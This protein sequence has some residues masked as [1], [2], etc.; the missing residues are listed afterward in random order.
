MPEIE[1][2]WDDDLDMAR[3]AKSF[4]QPAKDKKAKTDEL[5]I[6]L[7]LNI[8]LHN[9]DQNDTFVSDDYTKTEWNELGKGDQESYLKMLAEDHL[10]NYLDYGAS[11]VD[12]D[13]H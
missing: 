7:W 1:D 12:D 13:E 9:A 11:V 2:I 6:R 8:G 3:F 5:K 10:Q 4:K